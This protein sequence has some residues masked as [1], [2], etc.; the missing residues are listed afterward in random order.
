MPMTDI[1]FSQA[2]VS[3]GSSFRARQH[4]GA[5]RGALAAHCGGYHG[6]EDPKDRRS[7]RRHGNQHVR[8][9][10]PQVVTDPRRDC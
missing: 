3:L 1:D 8:L 4:V 6:L 2:Q 10:N 5:Y 7:L 9:R